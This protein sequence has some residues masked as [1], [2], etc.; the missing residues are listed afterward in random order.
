M[1]NKYNEEKHRQLGMN[2]STASAR[3]VKDTL[4]KLIVHSGQNQCHRCKEPMSRATF[5]L[6]HK[7]PWLH[8]DNPVDLFFDQDNI[9]FS[10]LVCNIASARKPMKKYATPEEAREAGKIKQKQYRTENPPAY[11]PEKRKQRYLQRGY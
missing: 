2:A 7:T 5:S 3:L 10:H 9:T 6:E 11:C 1:T 8:S 4:Y